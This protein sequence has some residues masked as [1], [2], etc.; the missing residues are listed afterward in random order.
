MILGSKNVSEDKQ[1]MPQSRSTT[2]PKH[3]KKEITLRNHAY[4]N[5]LKILQSKKE[6]FP[7]KIFD[8][9]YISAQNTDCGDSLEPPE[10][11]GSNEYPQS[12]VL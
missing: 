8:K 1:K 2:F 9:F 4:S 7:I 5:I 6:N 3:Q 10:R 11:H 12:M